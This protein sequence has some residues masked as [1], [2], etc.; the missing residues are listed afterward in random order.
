MLLEA[1]E[2]GRMAQVPSRRMDVHHS[3]FHVVP[4]TMV[5]ESGGPDSNTSFATN[6]PCDLSQVTSLLS[7]SVSSLVEWGY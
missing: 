5:L 7:P 6:Q 3:S 4:L 1:A 2:E